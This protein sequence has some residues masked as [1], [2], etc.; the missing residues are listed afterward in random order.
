MTASNRL[1]RLQELFAAAL[2]VPLG[3]RERWLE[4]LEHDDPSTI[5]ELRRLLARDE[6]SDSIPDG[7]PVSL[8]AS[9]L[10]I[11]ASVKPVVHAS[12][13]DFVLHEELGHG[14]MGCVFRGI[15]ESDGIRQE[16]AIKILRS[17]LRH[18]AAMQRFLAERR[19]LA[20]LEHPGIARLLDAGETED[21]TPFVAMELV[22]GQKLLDHCAEKQLDMAARVGVFRQLVAAV[23]HAHRALVVHRDIKPSN[24]M[25]DIEGRVRLLDFGIAKGLVD[26]GHAT[27]TVDRYFTPA[28]AAPEQLTGE[29]ITVACDVYSLGAL[30]Y[31]LLSGV[32]PFSVAGLRAADVERLILATPPPPMETVIET[33]GQNGA[34]A[35]SADMRR[36]WR[37]SLRGDL[38]SIVQRALRKEPQLRYASAA[39]L[40]RDLQNWLEHRPVRASGTHRIY[41][42]RKFLR[43]N[44]VAA[45][46]TALVL[47]SVAIAAVLIVRQGVIASR[48]RDRAREALSALSEAFVAADPTGLSGGAISARSILDAASRRISTHVASQPEIY[49]ELAAEVG[50]VQL[51]LGVIDA[52]D[53]SMIQALQWARSKPDQTLLARRLSLLQARRLVAQHAF[54]EADQAL[55]LLERERDM[56]SHVMLTRGKY[57]IARSEPAKAIPILKDAAA[58]LS[59]NVIDIDRIDA[60][61]QL[62]IAQRLGGN[63]AA[64]LDTLESLLAQIEPVVD[65]NH[66]IVLLTRLR[67]VDALLDLG[68]I[69]DAIAVA[70]PLTASIESVYGRKSS[71]TALTWSVLALTLVRAERYAESVAPY[72]NAALS[73]SESLGANHVTTARS[74]FNLALMQN[75]VDPGDS[76]SAANFRKAIAA[77]TIARDPTDPLV[78][79]FRIEYA[80][81]LIGRSEM[82]AAREVLLPENVTPDLNAAGP[83]IAKVYIEQ[84]SRLFESLD[85]PPNQTTVTGSSQADRAKALIC[86][87]DTAKVDS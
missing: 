39:A 76:S 81:S 78:T 10:A 18:S 45:T 7:M 14:G 49:A 51:A 27:A 87:A 41:R 47:G 55:S 66:A 12:A 34:Q 46:A 13:G 56:D 67:T 54:E 64:A 21:G 28:Y 53:Q 5:D 22:R 73:Y 70:Q 62:A 68:R 2:E 57:W 25:V 84:L 65:G 86:R 16:A 61:W 17:E 35:L 63:P 37:K 75:Y 9:A 85:C 26:D 3:R 72:L 23:I 33:K 69:D 11:S 44:G 32:P 79:F 42:A 30:L 48:E 83:D 50:S 31:E 20:R 71:I 74:F 1:R 6:K 43:R 8:L 19:M 59:Q 38:E 60:Q 82:S 80:K 24:V 15:R 4:D 77:A 36:Q 40:D 52:D 29:P 58:R